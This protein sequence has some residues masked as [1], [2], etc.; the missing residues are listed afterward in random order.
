MWAASQGCSRW[1]QPT[2]PSPPFHPAHSNFALTP[3]CS[4]DGVHARALG[5]NSCGGKGCDYYSKKTIPG[6]GIKSFK[7]T[8]QNTCCNKCWSDSYCKY[9][10]WGF[11]GNRKNQCYFFGSADDNTA[12]TYTQYYNSGYGYC[13]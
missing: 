7:T 3:R 11:K 8:E 10:S 13:T 1:W 12:W 6:R 9:W 2:Q 5:I 4:T